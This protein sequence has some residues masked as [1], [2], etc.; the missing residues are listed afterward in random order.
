MFGFGQSSTYVSPYFQRQPD[1]TWQIVSF[2]VP[3]VK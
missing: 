2:E 3:K 1:G